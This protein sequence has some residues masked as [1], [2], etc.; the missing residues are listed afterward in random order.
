VVPA[1]NEE[2]QLGKTL[3]AIWEYLRARGDDFELIV[4]DDGSGD[5]TVAVVESFASDHPGCA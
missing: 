3:S 5:R 2:V 4:V 1:Y